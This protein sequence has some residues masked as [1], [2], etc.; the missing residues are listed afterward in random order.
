MSI[1]SVRGPVA[2]AASRRRHKRIFDKNRQF[3]I[4]SGDRE[5]H[6]NNWSEGGFLSSGLENY[7]ANDLVEGTMEGPDGKPVQ[8]AG[9]VVRV[10][11]DGMRAVQLV[12]LDS[13][14]LL[15]MQS[16]DSDDTAPDS[17]AS[18]RAYSSADKVSGDSNPDS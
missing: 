8:F 16:A 18:S 2:A 4:K 14:A 17:S 6:T 5:G 13:A 7:G 11:D 10:Q 3:R 15:T 1:Q 12:G 9:K